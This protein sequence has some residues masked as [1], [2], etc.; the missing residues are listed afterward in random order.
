MT[1]AEARAILNVGVNASRREISLK[2][3]ILS[4]KYHPDKWALGSSNDSYAVRMEKFQIIANTR[5]FLVRQTFLFL[6]AI[7]IISIDPLDLNSKR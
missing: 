3:K 4:R 5:D 7:V 1:H 6:C 2:F